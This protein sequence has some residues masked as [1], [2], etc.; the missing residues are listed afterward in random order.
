MNSS[1]DCG[2]ED[3]GGQINDTAAIINRGEDT[4]CHFLDL[5]RVLEKKNEPSL[6]QKGLPV[7]LMYCSNAAKEPKNSRMRRVFL[8]NR[9]FVSLVKPLEG[10]LEFLD[11]VGQHH[12][13]GHSRDWRHDHF[14]YCNKR[15]ERA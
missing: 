2:I 13:M 15:L 12:Q 7:L 8:A 5:I 3:K 1:S 14:K 4:M 10:A 11:A 6:L 9:T